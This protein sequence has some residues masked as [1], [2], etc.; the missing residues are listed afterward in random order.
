MKTDI[1][2][3]KFAGCDLHNNDNKLYNEVLEALKRL[4]K[5]ET[6]LRIPDKMDISS[7]R[8]FEHFMIR[9]E[10]NNNEIRLHHTC[11]RNGI[12]TIEQFATTDPTVFMK[13]RNVG[14]K[15]IAIAEERHKEARELFGM[16]PVEFDPSDITYHFN[17]KRA[18]G[19][20]HYR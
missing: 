8:V 13:M 5:L 19:V 12:K 10:L 1:L 7:D 18:V 3:E 6:C 14:I 9:D 17:K 20:W 2:I 15:L 4:Q 16:A 11:V